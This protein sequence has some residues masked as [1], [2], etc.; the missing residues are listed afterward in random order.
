M[1]DAFLGIDPSYS[2]FATVLLRPDEDGA[3]LGHEVKQFA[4]TPAKYGTGADRLF[5]VHAELRDHFA[6]LRDQ[7]EVKHICLEGYAPAS[8][9][10][11]EALGELGGVTRLALAET[12]PPDQL[13]IVAPTALK[14]YVTGSGSSGK[15]VVILHVFKKWG[16]EFSSNDQADAYGLAQVARGIVCGTNLKYEEQVVQ[17]LRRDLYPEL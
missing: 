15:D 16:V 5:H 13:T 2:G 11:R 12:W 3:S 6:A 1:L 4:F 10:N 17:A 8:K 7:Y 14:K 9:F